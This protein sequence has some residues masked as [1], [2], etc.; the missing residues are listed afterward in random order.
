MLTGK[1]LHRADDLLA[2]AAAGDFI[3]PIEQQ[4]DAPGSE[5]GVHGLG[6]AAL[7]ALRLQMVRDIVPEFGGAAGGL[8]ISGESLRERQ[9]RQKNRNQA[10]FSAQPLPTG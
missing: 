4:Q 6:Q 5:F 8:R 9:Q 10:S 2:C 3:Q 7:R 1:L